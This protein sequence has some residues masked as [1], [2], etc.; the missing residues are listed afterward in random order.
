MP[1][2]LVVLCVVLALG[3]DSV[4][5]LMRF[6][7]AAI[8]DGQWW[9]LLGGHLVHLGAGHVVMNMVALGLAAALLRGVL[10]ATEW[11]AGVLLSALAIDA[12]LYWLAPETVWYVGLSGVLHGV[13]AAGALQLIA[14]RSWL[15]GVLLAGI[16]VKLVWEQRFGATPMSMSVSGG[17]VIVDAHLFGALGGA[18]SQIASL[19]VRRLRSARL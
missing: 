18:L 12:G 8:E 15:G 6:E 11:L 10:T 17:P 7:R 1:G 4:R 5:E 13:L 9:R 3:G 2:A 19:G 14:G 16:V